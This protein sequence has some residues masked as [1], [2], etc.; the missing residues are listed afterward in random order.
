MLAAL[1]ASALAAH[2]RASAWTYP[3]VSAGHILGVAMLVGAVL[4]MDARVLAGR[5]V[6][7]AVALLRPWAAAG[8]APAAA[9]GPALFVFQATDYTENLWFRVK[10]SAMLAALA[11]AALH[12]RL[13]RLPPPRARRAA[14]LSLALWPAALLCGRLIAFS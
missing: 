9:C 2:L 6:Q 13:D 11:N 12:L 4:P 10:F 1:E 14:I 5:D 8:L 7:G 3:L